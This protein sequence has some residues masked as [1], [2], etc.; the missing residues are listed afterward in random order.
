MNSVRNLHVPCLLFCCLITAAGCRSIKTPVWSRHYDVATKYQHLNLVLVNTGTCAEYA[1]TTFSG[2]PWCYFSEE[3]GVCLAERAASYHPDV[4]VA[5]EMTEEGQVVVF[6]NDHLNHSYCAYDPNE[7]WEAVLSKD[8]AQAQCFTAGK[9]VQW[10]Y[11][12]G[13]FYLLPVHFHSHPAKRNPELRL[14]ANVVDTLS[15]P[16]I[17]AGALEANS[18]R[19]KFVVGKNDCAIFKNLMRKSYCATSSLD[20][21]TRFWWW[22]PDA[23]LLSNDI[24]II[25]LAKER[26]PC[27]GDHDLI[28]ISVAVPERKQSPSPQ[29]TPVLLRK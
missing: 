8:E 24:R 19:G 28:A 20:S 25:G 29:A 21:T 18:I 10:L 2:K 5:M 6:N 22:A 1:T 23:I 15:K 4:L 16:F 17:V 14:L 12:F 27:A 26:M 11:D 13:V 9:A 3:R 7:R